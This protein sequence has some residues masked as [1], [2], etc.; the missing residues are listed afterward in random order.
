MSEVKLVKVKLIPVTSSILQAIGYD[1][2][3]ILHVQ[4]KG[5]AIYT[6]ENV[7]L[8]LYEELK[9]AKSVGAF[10]MANIKGKKEYPYKLLKKEG[11]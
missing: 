9:S 7:P 4:F 5:G 10:F 2:V 8:G 11:S 1:P 3:G 6:Y